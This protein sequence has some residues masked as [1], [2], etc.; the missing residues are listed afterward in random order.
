MRYEVDKRS[1]LF[2]L[3]TLFFLLVP[4]FVDIPAFLVVPWIVVAS[5]FSFSACVIN[6]NHVHLPIFYSR[7][8]NFIFNLLL[9]LA[10]GHTSS[11]VIIPH[12]MNHH[13]H[14]GSSLDWIRPELAGGGGRLTRLARYIA[15]ASFEMQVR[16]R[17]KNAPRLKGR[18]ARILQLEKLFLYACIA[19]LLYTSWHKSLM[20]VFIPWFI[21]ILLLVGVNLLQHEGCD[22]SSPYDHSRNFTSPILNWF[23]FNNGYHSIHHLRPALHWSQLPEKH[24]TLVAPYNRSDLNQRSLIAYLLSL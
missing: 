8:L 10:K 4:L 2:V 20:F 22:P 7:R 21:G 11:T 16:R 9:T 12:N 24:N 6:H 5:L 17:S 19:C 13:V 3:A 1:I 15:S 18:K 14:N 23:C